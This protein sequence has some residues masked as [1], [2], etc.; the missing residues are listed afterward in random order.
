MCSSDFSVAKNVREL[1][2]QLLLTNIEP[3]KD[4]LNTDSGLD[5]E[6]FGVV[7][8]VTCLDCDSSLV[9]AAVGDLDNGVLF[10]SIY[11]TPHYKV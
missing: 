10:L 4:D 11:I 8:G 1:G 2:Y 3:R 6:V 9:K 5:T 7:L